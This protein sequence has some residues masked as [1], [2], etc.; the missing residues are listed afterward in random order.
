MENSAPNGPEVRGVAGYETPYPYMDVLQEK[1]EERLAHRVPA[2]GRFCGFC[3]GRLRE[4]DETCPFCSSPV[5]GPG[6]PG[7]RTVVPEIPQE[8]LRAYRAKQRTEASWVYGGAFVGLIVA[9]VLFIVMVT[10]GPGLLGHPAL[11][12]AVLIGGGYALAQFFGPLL[13]GQV[14]YRRGARKRDAMWAAYLDQR[15]APGAR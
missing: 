8:V 10:W 6:S 2:A 11:A 14:G 4:T 9:S 12:F 13:G 15:D 1:M 7:A 3:Y 5:A